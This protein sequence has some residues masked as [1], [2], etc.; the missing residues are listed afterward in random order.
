MDVGKAWLNLNKSLNGHP[1]QSQ[2]LELQYHLNTQLSQLERQT[3]Q[4]KACNATLE[5][6]LAALQLQ[7]LSLQASS[8]ETEC[9]LTALQ[10]SS[11]ETEIKLAEHKAT[12][13]G[14]LELEKW[15]V[16]AYTNARKQLQQRKYCRLSFSASAH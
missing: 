9:T 15:L 1:A 13:V 4:L 6:N 14:K 7:H 11:R 16:P 2:A 5:S 3:E 10:A 8:R 12:L